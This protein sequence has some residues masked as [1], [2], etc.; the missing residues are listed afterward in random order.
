MVTPVQAIQLCIFLVHNAS[1]LSHFSM[2]VLHGLL[3]G[4][5]LL[6]A[7]T[8]E[9]LRA[10]ASAWRLNLALLLGCKLLLCLRQ[11]C[12]EGTET[13]HKAD[14]YS[15]LTAFCSCAKPGNQAG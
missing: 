9:R 5:Q 6:G 13:H 14:V 15:S 2:Q 11:C 8:V 1:E 12:L 3:Q 7:D 4:S 10:A